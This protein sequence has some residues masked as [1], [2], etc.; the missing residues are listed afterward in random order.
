M[1]TDRKTVLDTIGYKD[2][3]DEIHYTNSDRACVIVSAAAI[4]DSLRAL[5][6]TFMVDYKLDDLFS[7][8]GPLSSFSSKIK[9]SYNLGLISKQE[10]DLIEIIR[11]I[12]N[13]YAHSKDYFSL[14]EK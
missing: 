6:S 1:P 9:M 11:R 8:N 2:F 4:D 3:Y 12:R 10:H 7:G 14:E 13:D 5:L